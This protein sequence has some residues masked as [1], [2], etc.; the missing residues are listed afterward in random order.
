MKEDKTPPSDFNGASYALWL[1]TR[2]PVSPANN[3]VSGIIVFLVF[4]LGLGGLLG[5]IGFRALF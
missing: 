5:Y 1:E 2:Q 4:I 3:R